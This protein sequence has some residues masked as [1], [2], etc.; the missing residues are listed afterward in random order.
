MQNGTKG[1]WI[2]EEFS[3]SFFLDMKELYDQTFVVFLE[4][5]LCYNGATS[6]KQGGSYEFNLL[7]HAVTLLILSC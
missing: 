4:D 5:K 7:C 3:L 2:T 6:V 1:E